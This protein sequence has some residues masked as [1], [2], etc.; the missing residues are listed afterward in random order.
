M[1]RKNRNGQRQA[2]RPL[3]LKGIQMSMSIPTDTQAKTAPV[4]PKPGFVQS[5]SEVKMQIGRAHV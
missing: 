2:K 4:A 3:N 1:S 5:A